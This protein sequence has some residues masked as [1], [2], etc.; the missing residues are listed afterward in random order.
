MA[1]KT[2]NDGPSGGNAACFAMVA[3]ALDDY[4]EKLVDMVNNSLP[5][6]TI[7]DINNFTMRYKMDQQ[8]AAKPAYANQ[9]Q[10]CQVLRER[11]IL[12]HGRNEPFKRALA[13]R[14]NKLFPPQ[15]KLVSNGE[16]VSRRLLPGLYTVL[17]K[18]TGADGL[19][20]GHQ[21]CV[22]VIG[23]LR[24]GADGHFLW[25]DLYASPTVRAA[26][27]DLLMAV[28]PHFSNVHKR[29]MW[30]CDMINNNLAMVEE[31]TFEGP[32]ERNWQLDEPA[33]LRVVRELFADF[34]PR[35]KS[36]E[37]AKPLIEKYGK[38]QVQTLLA[39]LKA[40][41]NAGA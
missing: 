34:R 31:Y 16:Y 20:A 13:M 27:D 21:A 36:T 7:A 3:S 30:M 37:A 25:E 14:I 29:A 5:G 9:Y 4:T 11:E 12:D 1:D 41:D 24:K 23:S 38:D 2:D 15:G 32:A 40:L 8:A 22:D 17:E 28:V 33:T 6:I 10:H 39:M 26:V 19:T 35:L 18:M